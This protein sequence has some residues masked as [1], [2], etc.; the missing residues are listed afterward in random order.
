[1]EEKEPIHEKL[2]TYVIIVTGIL[3]ILMIIWFTQMRLVR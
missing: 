3:L 2:M 1:M